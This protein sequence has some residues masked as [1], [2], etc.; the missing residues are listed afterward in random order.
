MKNLFTAVILGIVLTGVAFAQ[1]AAG[2]KAEV[3]AAVVEFT[4]GANA[5]EMNA[6]A[7]RQLQTNLAAALAKSD[8]YDVADVRHTQRA[9]KANLADINSG[10]STTAAVKLGKLLGVK[11][12]VTGTVTEYTPKDADGYGSVAIKTRVIEVA[13]GKVIH[14]G[15]ATHRSAKEMK[16]GSSV[17]MQA[18]VVKPAILKLAAEI[19]ELKL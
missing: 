2:K 17:E 13:T 9:S 7:K 1:T 18:F 8:K 6:D 19:L 5:S 16:T 3:D 12:V 10:S 15:E 4:P 11:Y 14:T